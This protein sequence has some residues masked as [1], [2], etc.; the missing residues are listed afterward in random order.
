MT[1]ETFAFLRHTRVQLPDGTRL[2]VEDEAFRCCEGLV[3]LEKN[4]QTDGVRSVTF[5]L[6]S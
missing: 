1:K 3:T 6:T 5:R 2:T 4:D